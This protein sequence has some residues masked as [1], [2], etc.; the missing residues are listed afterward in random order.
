M[1]MQ[2]IKQNICLMFGGKSVEHDISILT[3]IQALCAMDKTKYNVFAVYVSKGGEFFCVPNSVSA[4]DFINVDKLKKVFEP[5]CFLPSDNA[6]YKMDKNRKKLKR[7]GIIDAVIVAMHGQNGEDGSVSGLLQLA[8]IPYSC[9][10]VVSSAICMD[11]AYT[12]D[13]FRAGGFKTMPYYVLREKDF[14]DGRDKN[15][16]SAI[17]KLGLPII[18]K[19]SCLGSSIGISSCEN[20]R[21]LIDGIE[22]ALKFSDKVVLE[23]MLTNFVEVNCSAMGTLKE[24]E[25]SE[26]E[27]PIAMKDFLSFEDKYLVG[28]QKNIHSSKSVQKMKRKLDISDSLVEKIK[29]LT[30]ELYICFD[31]KGV[32]RVDYMVERETNNIY[33]NEINTIPGSLAYFLWQRDGC[34]FDTFIDRLIELAKKTHT[35]NETKLS[36]FA[37]S[38]LESG[39]GAKMRKK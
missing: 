28:T 27:Q 6:I 7:L 26:C 29:K 14:E 8:N 21:E 5:I 30:K 16:K 37:S 18:V 22:L 12:K 10:G 15:I 9:C 1:F 32:V 24:V 39:S 2:N 31:C 20:E 4:S 3:G 34:G 11:K 33:V 19:P 17:K 23:K 13:I 36:S 38:V 35:S 25:I